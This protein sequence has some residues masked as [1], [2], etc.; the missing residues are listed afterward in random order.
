MSLLNA[1]A[2]MMAIV[3]ST[4]ARAMMSG[5]A[6]PDVVLVGKGGLLGGGGG[7]ELSNEIGGIAA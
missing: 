5:W 7:V 1:L 2:G 4:V 6:D 3:V